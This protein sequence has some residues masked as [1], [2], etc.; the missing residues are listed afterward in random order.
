MA[1]GFLRWIFSKGVLGRPDAQNHDPQVRRPAN[2]IRSRAAIERGVSIKEN[3]W[4][5]LAGGLI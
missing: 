4:F 3:V 1:T 2:I 5:G